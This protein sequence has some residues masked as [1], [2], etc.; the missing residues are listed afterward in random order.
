MMGKHNSQPPRNWLSRNT[1]KIQILTLI[2]IIG[3]SLG[4]HRTLGA[5]WGGLS[6]VLFGLITL[7][8]FVTMGID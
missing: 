7:G 1:F 2:L 3:G 6:I 8:M 4:L 5:G